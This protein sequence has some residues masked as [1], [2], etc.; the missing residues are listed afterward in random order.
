M[1]K[2]NGKREAAKTLTWCES[3]DI[4]YLEPSLYKL[5]YVGIHQP[6]FKKIFVLLPAS[7][8][9]KNDRQ[10]DLSQQ[11]SHLIHRQGENAIP[12]TEGNHRSSNF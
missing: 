4:I 3:S 7:R 10:I 6:R 8:Y 9:K 1:K 11:E 5:F 12:E 2:N